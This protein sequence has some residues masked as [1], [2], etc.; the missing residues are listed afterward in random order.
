MNE[1][2]IRVKGKKKEEKPQKRFG[3]NLK[4]GWDACAMFKF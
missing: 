3:E 4:F 1:R 2:R